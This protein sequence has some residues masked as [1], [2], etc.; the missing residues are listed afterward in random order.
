VRLS[1]EGH[2]TP[3]SW[4]YQRAGAAS[5]NGREAHTAGERNVLKIIMEDMEPGEVAAMYEEDGDAVIL[6]AR[7]LSDDQR[8][9]AVNNL[10]AR[11]DVRL[12]PYRFP[13]LV[14]RAAQPAGNVPAAPG[15]LAVHRLAR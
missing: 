10:L 13:R 1:P 7:H 14:P 5:N 3:S 2:K 15:S 8:C 6:I 11:V 9:E 4:I 12:S